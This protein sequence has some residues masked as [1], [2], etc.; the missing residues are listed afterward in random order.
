MLPAVVAAA[1]TGFVVVLAVG[2]TPLVA[3]AIAV[4]AA[5]VPPAVSESRRRAR[6]E[7][8]ADRWPDVLAA[9]RSDLAAGR[10]V[11]EAVVSAGHRVG[12]AFDGLAGEIAGDLAAGHTFA[13][14]AAAARTTW[15][16][17]VADRILTTLAAAS[18]TG[19]DRVSSILGALA[20]SVSDELRLR[21]AHDAALTQQRLTSAVALIA[22]WVLLI[23]TTATNPQAAEAL[24]TGAGPLIVGGGLAATG[25]GYLLA[26]R[27]ARL[28]R[29]PRLFT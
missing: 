3:G 23:L 11:A 6:A 20:S 15:S 8:I 24:S 2:G 4:L 12:G 14:A 1:I 19:G 26:R 29:P 28:A 13:E 9:V 21:R 7:A 17:P 25:V 22:P 5:S 27:A 18:V 16:D 10:S